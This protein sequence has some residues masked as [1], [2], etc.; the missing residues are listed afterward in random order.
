MLVAGPLVLCELWFDMRSRSRRLVPELAG[1]IGVSSVAAMILL[2]DDRSARLAAGVWLVLSARAVT[3]IPHVRG[4][5]A[6]LHGRPESSA[7]TALADCAAITVAII[8]GSL[9][10]ALV[11]GT[12]AVIAVVAIQRITARRALPRVAVLGIRQ[13]LLG[14]AVVLATAVGVLAST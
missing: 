8:A 2:A 9:D 4:L 13:M 1:A 5:I 14:L 3:S 11:A 7:T 10:H 6:R 12:T